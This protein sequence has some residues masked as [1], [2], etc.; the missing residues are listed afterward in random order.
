MNLSGQDKPQ[1]ELKDEFGEITSGDL[2]ARVD[3]F[4]TELSNQKDAKGYIVSYA[5]P[6]IV[7]RYKEIITSHLKMRKVPLKRF[8]FLV[9]RNSRTPVF[10]FW[11][12]PRRAIAPLINKPAEIASLNLSETEGTISCLE[13]KDK[14]ETIFVKT[15]AVDAENDD[16]SYSYTVSGG[17]IIG[18]GA[19]VKWDLSGA[20]PGTYAITVGVDDGKGISEQTKTETV[21]F[22]D[23]HCPKKICEC[24][25]LSVSGPAA[26]VKPGEIMIFT[27]K[28]SGGDEQE[29]TYSWT[30]DK[31][32]IV[33]GRGTPTI[34]VATD[35]LSDETIRAT[36]VINCECDETEITASGVGVVT[37]EPKPILIDKFRFHPN[38]SEDLFARIDNFMI[39][40]QNNPT[41]S[42]YIISY[43]IPKAI[44]NAE[45]QI[46][47][48]IKHRGFD[49]G[50][51]V[52]VN[53]GGT[54]K[55]AEIEFWSV[56]AGADASDIGK[57]Y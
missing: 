20:T 6:E 29:T 11:I 14:H 19:D 33:A 21:I 44:A 16:L 4:V 10:Q 38:S 50:R 12:V 46:K 15:L 9:G 54:S 41:S 48:W 28:V 37:A 53:G 5:S 56:P 17:R 30:I 7:Q 36:V 49:P 42:G 2:K 43:G 47:S 23:I 40:L 25:N 32:E 34:Q 24:P 27:A 35:G 3:S 22:M 18:L 1:T 39:D 51:I 31:G 45:K 13:F 55:I 57:T 52:L 26:A 8:V